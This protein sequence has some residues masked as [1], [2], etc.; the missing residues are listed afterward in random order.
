MLELAR[1]HGPRWGDA[2][3]DDIEFL[4][5]RTADDAANLQMIWTMMLPGFLGTYAGHLDREGVELIERFGE[6]IPAWIEGRNMPTTVTHG[7]YR[8]DNLMFQS[9]AG[10]YPVAA[11]DWQTPGQGPASAD[12]AYFM[13]A[14]PLPEDRRAMERGLVHDYL[15]ALSGYGVVV[16]AA[17]FFRHYARDAFGGVIMS[18]VASQIV[19]ASDRSEAMFTA[20]ATRHTRH[21]LDLGSESLI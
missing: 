12:V 5:R 11:V 13:G 8:L 21:V 15:E 9:P 7:D 10:G 2:S 16:D 17:E 20:M 1:L 4:Q 14:G 18:V 19:G 3:L 6:R